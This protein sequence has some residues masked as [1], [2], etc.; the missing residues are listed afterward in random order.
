MAD[1]MGAPDLGRDVPIFYLVAG[2]QPDQPPPPPMISGPVIAVL[3]AAS[4]SSWRRHSD[5][6]NDKAAVRQPRDITSRKTHRRP[7]SAHR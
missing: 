4:S 3:C 2:V 5:Q 7:S 1:D 6:P